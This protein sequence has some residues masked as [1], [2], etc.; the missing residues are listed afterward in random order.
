M[1]T[2][3]VS[4]FKQS[5]EICMSDFLSRNILDVSATRSIAIIKSQSFDENDFRRKLFF[6]QAMK[7]KEFIDVKL[8]YYAE[9][10]IAALGWNSLSN[11]DVSFLHKLVFGKTGVIYSKYKD[12]FER[13][14]DSIDLF[15]I[16]S[17]YEIKND[18]MSHLELNFFGAKEAYRFISTEFGRNSFVDNIDLINRVF[19]DAC[20]FCKKNYCD[21]HN[22]H[23]IEKVPYMT[24]NSGPIIYNGSLFGYAAGLQYKDPSK[25]VLDFVTNKLGYLNV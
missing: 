17:H 2:D 8:Q 7:N 1:T 5:L 18:L 10:L 22:Y 6:G 25:F 14:T 11:Q 16:F 21:T 15:S 19:D 23:K 13:T 20:I 4:Y 24:Y 3:I 12:T 9:R